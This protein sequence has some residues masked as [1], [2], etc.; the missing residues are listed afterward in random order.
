M[1]IARD[2]LPTGMELVVVVAIHRAPYQ[3]HL[4]S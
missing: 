2:A 1:E 4:S 3:A